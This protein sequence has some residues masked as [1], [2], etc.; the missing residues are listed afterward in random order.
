VR[1]EIGYYAL[2]SSPIGQLTLVA[3]EQSITGVYF[4][5][6]KESNSLVDS[7]YKISDQHPVLCAAKKQLSEYFAGKR[8]IF[9]LP[10]RPR[11]TVFQLKAWKELQKIPYGKTI[12]YGEQARR[13]GDANKARAVGMANGRNPI[14]II[15][16]CH[17]VVGADGSLTGFGGGLKT[18]KF[19]LDLEQRFVA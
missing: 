14:S 6:S 13:V 12:A 9:D 7:R 10:L 2:F 15:V 8:K 18:K 19:L 3:E 4:E 11:G 5:C 1:S 17:R 16:P